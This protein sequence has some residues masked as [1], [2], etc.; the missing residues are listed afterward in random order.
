MKTNSLKFRLPF[1][2]AAVILLL[3]CIGIGRRCSDSRKT[4]FTSAAELTS[5]DTLAVAIEMSPLTYTFANDTA[6]GFDYHII[7]DIARLHGL[8]VKFYPVANLEEAYQ[9]LYDGKY[10]LVVGNMPATAGLR[11]V[12]P[13]TDDVY[14]GRQVLVQRRQSDS[15]LAVNS[16]LD[17]RG[18]TVYLA[19]GSPVR[20]RLGNMAR[21]MGDTVVIETLPD[22]SSEHLAIMTAL[23]QIKHAVVSEAVARHVAADYPQLDYSTAVSFNQF[24]VWAT[25]PGDTVLRDSLNSWIGSFKQTDAYRALA[26]RFL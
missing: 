26:D 15:T 19:P 20:S 22:Y 1:I 5:G 17:L 8:N 10:S 23:G 21:E 25:A 24:Q 13:L 4:A 7:K 3:I 14:L 18:D 6:D 11:E 12:F 16:L 9:G 2:V